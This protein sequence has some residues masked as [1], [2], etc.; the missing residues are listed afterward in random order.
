M[1]RTLV[2]VL[3]AAAAAVEVD[4]ASRDR[5]APP[6]EVARFDATG[7]L[8]RPASYREWVWLSSGVGMAY[9]PNASASTDHPLF[10]NVFVAPA[11]YRSFLETGRWPDGTMLALEVR[12]S[13]STGSI[14]KAGLFQGALRGLE[15][16]VK[17]RGA[18]TF[19]AF[20]TE[21]S[22]AALP[23]TAS[24][25][26]CHAASGAVDNTFVQFYPTLVEVA[27][28]RGTLGRGHS[29]TP[30]EPQGRTDAGASSKEPR[31]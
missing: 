8:R 4:T 20:G 10:D 14:N 23:R 13:E 1:T 11:A 12:D 3:L 24:C 29:G 17:A 19:Y 25:Y 7:R 31:K 26:A 5:A 21:D 15:V 9:G 22:A 2:A 30:A 18:W 28:A 16:E 6:R 27:R